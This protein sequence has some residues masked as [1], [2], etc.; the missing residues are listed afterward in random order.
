MNTT[1]TDINSGSTPTAPTLPAN[2][3]PLFLATQSCELF[4]LRPQVDVTAD[5]PRKLLS[6]QQLLADIQQRRA[7]SDFQPFKSWIDQYP[8]DQ[9]MLIVY[10]AEWV[11]GQNFYLCLTVEAM[12]AILNVSLPV[13]LVL[14]IVNFD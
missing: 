1:A 5:Q 12:Q 10:D 9:G 7:V 6:K 11:Y 14:N 13:C 3:Q 2:C 4:Q 8:D